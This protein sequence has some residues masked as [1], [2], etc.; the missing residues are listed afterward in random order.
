MGGDV[1]D[2]IQ[3]IEEDI[4]EIAR[5]PQHAKWFTLTPAL[6]EK[7]RKEK[8]RKDKRKAS[9]LT[10][11]TMTDPKTATSSTTN[12]I[13]S[14]DTSD[15]EDQLAE[16]E[17]EPPT[18]KLKTRPKITA[19]IEIVAAPRTLKEKPTPLSRGPFFFN[20]DTTRIDFLQSLASCCVEG[21]YAPTITSINHHQLFWKLQVPANDRKRPLSTEDGFR[22]LID[23]LADL[24]Q[25]KKDTTIILSLPPLTRVA[26]NPADVVA[27]KRGV[28]LER[29]EF[30][31]GPLG[32]TIREQ[33]LAVCEGTADILD[34][35]RINF[36]IGM[37]M[38]FPDKR[39]Y[40]SGPDGLWELTTLRLQVWASH[41][42]KGT[43]TLDA[44]PNSV[45]F[46]ESQRLR[47]PTKVREV[48]ALPVAPQTPA[49][50]PH[51][52]PNQGFYPFGG[53]PP[54]F[55]PPYPYP[56]YPPL[57]NEPNA[58]PYPIPPLHG[59]YPGPYPN[60]PAPPL[61]TGPNLNPNTLGTRPHTPGVARDIAPGS[62]PTSPLKI[63]LPRPVSLDEFCD[64]YGIDDEDRARLSK[65]KVQPGDRRVEKLD[66]ED[67]QGHAG[68]AKLSWDDFI[69]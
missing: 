9:R 61:T 42:A 63:V 48:T 20:L 22:V 21:H 53:F 27:G 3:G 1:N 67:W 50:V 56:F 4:R 34:K 10:L 5:D 28:D 25:K 23:K 26:A 38:R 52:A 51:F 7:K 16:K 39:V 18:K 14:D 54:Y 43:A 59:H 35:L 8:A 60:A 2:D 24:S 46:S 47:I 30:K 11:N 31:E 41:I 12:D 45:H 33:Q 49:A 68:F 29:E 65:L 44:P 58:A 13:S 37:D 19:Y 36:P 55:P 6:E 40:S 15:N 32:S 57:G 62:A 17:N 69:T 66:R 64:H